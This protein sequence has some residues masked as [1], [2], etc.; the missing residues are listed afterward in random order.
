MR[1]EIDRLDQEVRRLNSELEKMNHLY[2]TRVQEYG[3]LILDWNGLTKALLD[4]G[5]E[6]WD[7]SEDGTGTSNSVEWNWRYQGREGHGLRSLAD[8]IRMA[9]DTYYLKLLE[10]KQGQG[11]KGAA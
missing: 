11:Q 8:C 9:F 2:R 1:R 3:T 5:L 7:N 10:S 6:V 4:V